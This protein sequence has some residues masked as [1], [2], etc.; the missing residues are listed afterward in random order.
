[1]SSKIEL[2]KLRNKYFKNSNDLSSLQF[3]PNVSEEQSIKIKA[4]QDKAFKKYQFMKKI[5]KAY[6]KELRKEADNFEDC[7]VCQNC[8]ETYSI[9][10][11]GTSELAM[12]DQICKYCMSDGYGR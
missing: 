7:F 5:S 12:Q 1:M 2:I 11:M 3:E 9:E 10:E 6:D 4:E 8:R